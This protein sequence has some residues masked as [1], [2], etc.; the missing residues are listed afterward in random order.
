MEFIVPTL[1]TFEKVCRQNR[2]IKSAT[3]NIVIKYLDPNLSK[4]PAELSRPMAER[5]NSPKPTKDQG[6]IAK[7]TKQTKEQGTSTNPMREQGTS[8][9]PSKKT[10]EQG[11]ST[12]PMR[13]QGTSPMPSKKT[14]EQGTSPTQMN[15]RG[16]T[17][18]ITVSI[19]EPKLNIIYIKFRGTYQ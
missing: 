5:E 10:K 16:K 13:E 8:P 4:S 6:I 1:Q 9:M 18:Y 2:E 12:N 17:I 14:K 19:Y 7:P 3:C 11:T 15:D